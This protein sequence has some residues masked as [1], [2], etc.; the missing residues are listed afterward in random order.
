MRG[1]VPPAG[2]RFGQGVISRRDVLDR[3]VGR[4]AGSIETP[5]QRRLDVVVELVLARHDLRLRFREFHQFGVDHDTAE[6][7]VLPILRDHRGR[8]DGIELGAGSGHVGIHGRF[9]D[10]G[11]HRAACQQ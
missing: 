2:K 6:A 8:G 1:R 7:V 11:L 4:V 10:R 9:L 3:Q 5:G